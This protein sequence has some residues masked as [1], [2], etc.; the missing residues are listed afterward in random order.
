VRSRVVTQ[1]IRRVLCIFPG[2]A[3]SFG[4]FS[5]AQKL[6]GARAFMPPQGLLVVAGYL[7][8]SWPVRFVDENIRRA[9]PADF[10]WADVVFS[11]GMHIQAARIRDIAQRAR[12]AGKVC[13]LGGPAVSASPDSHPEFDYLHIGELGDATDALIARLDESIEPPPRQVR[14][15]TKQRLPLVQFPLPAYDQARL[16]KYLIGTLQF[17]SGCPYLCE[18]CDIPSLYGRQPRYKSPQQLITE[19][20]FIRSQK[21]YPPSIYFVDD[22]FIGNRKATREMLPYLIEWQRANGYPFSFACEATLNIAKQRDILALMREA[23]FDTIF[24]GI[25]TPELDALKAMH[26]EHNASLPMLEA[27]RTINGYGFD[28]ASGIILGLDTDTA[29]T[30]EHLKTFIDRSHVPMLTINLLQAL[31]RTALWTRLE[32]AGR[33]VEEAGRESNVQF[34]R[35]YEEVVAT[36]R[37]CIAHAYEPRRLYDRFIHQLEATHAHRLAVP[38]PGRLNWPNVRRGLLLMGNLLVRVGVLADYRAEFWRMARH[39]LRAGRFESMLGMGF[40]SYH[41]IEF[42]REA[43]RG[44]Q[45]ASFY[46]ARARETI[47]NERPEGV[48]RRRA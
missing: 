30:E 9:T 41:L 38:T 14:F 8:A 33:L 12:A 43:L 36:W 3:P 42:S 28:V 16:G 5:H 31:P 25:E 46:S 22:N 48:V 18:F 6:V 44:D 24:V 34:L 35:P 47:G 45:N 15:Q 7:P 37:R 20:E 1:N 39:A 17:S 19:L 4:T 40:V 21:S 13:V 32:S 23:C 2:Y 26:K 27:I 10:A 29:S 11:S